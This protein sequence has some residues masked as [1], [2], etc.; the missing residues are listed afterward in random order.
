M[1]AHGMSILVRRHGGT[2]AGRVATPLAT[3]GAHAFALGRAAAADALDLVAEHDHAYVEQ[4][5]DTSGVQALTADF[6]LVVPPRP[7]VIREPHG[8]PVEAGSY[9]YL[10]EWTALPY[11]GY[12][13]AFRT[14][15]E[16]AGAGMYYLNPRQRVVPAHPAAAADAWLGRYPLLEQ[17][18]DGVLHD[19]LGVVPPDA[20][21]FDLLVGDAGEL[22][23]DVWL[24]L[25]GYDPELLPNAYR[26]LLVF[27]QGTP[28]Y[29]GEG[30]R[31][32]W[33]AFLLPLN[34]PTAPGGIVFYIN[35][36]GGS[37]ELFGPVP[38][39]DGWS[40]GGGLFYLT[41]QAGP[42][43][44]DD[45][46]AIFIDGVERWRGTRA[47]NSKSLGTPIMT[48]G[49]GLY[50][51][52]GVP[53]VTPPLGAGSRVHYLRV[54]DHRQPADVVA[55][56]ARGRAREGRWAVE[57]HVDD[58]CRARRWLRPDAAGQVVGDLRAYVG[59]LGGVC[60]VRLVLRFGTPD[61]RMDSVHWGYTR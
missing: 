41:I 58:T 60:T 12:P 32:A 11:P 46:S 2:L 51:V 20:T 33:G 14:P 40:V 10:N 30:Q 31:P 6:Q 35:E 55:W 1:T 48:L 49:S 26:P 43:D 42:K 34:H 36:G 27:G 18:P 16:G 17:N 45:G 24:D 39:G 23:A 9:W 25:Q 21:A 54:L 15:V 3:E 47:L 37:V 5:V 50:V 38:A 8:Q 22:Q 61:V 52:G 57:L 19:V 53:K 56:E 59:D 28:A 7:E 29:G 4:D 44:E 13:Y